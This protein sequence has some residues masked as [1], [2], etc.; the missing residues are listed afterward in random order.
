[1]DFDRTELAGAVILRASQAN[2]A[3]GR[4]PS[5]KETAQLPELAT[6]VQADPSVRAQPDSQRAPKSGV[7]LWTYTLLKR[8]VNEVPIGSSK[9]NGR[10]GEIRTHDLLYPNLVLSRSLCSLFPLVRCSCP[11]R[12]VTNPLIA[13]YLLHLGAMRPGSS[14][15]K[16]CGPAGVV[17]N[18]AGAEIRAKSVRAVGLGSTLL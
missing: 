4:P 5:H 17:R 15:A 18:C 3:L 2:D 10:G 11:Y 8:P 7:I 9:K 16:L 1:M 13:S 12:Y 14:C 6:E